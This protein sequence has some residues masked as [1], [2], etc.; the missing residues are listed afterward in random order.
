MSNQEEIN[1]RPDE[2]GHA[3]CDVA[4]NCFEGFVSAFARSWNCMSETALSAWQWL[5]DS[6]F[7]SP[8]MYGETGSDSQV[9]VKSTKEKERS[10]GS[11]SVASHPCKNLKGQ[12]S[13]PQ[14]EATQPT[15]QI[16][17]NETTPQSTSIPS[18]AQRQGAPQSIKSSIVTGQQNLQSTKLPS[19][20][21]ANASLRDSRKARSDSPRPPKIDFVETGSIFGDRKRHSHTNM[22][23][24]DNGRFKSPGRPNI[25]TGPGGRAIRISF[26]TGFPS[27]KSAESR[28]PSQ[29]AA[30]RIS[31]RSGESE[32][33][34]S[35]SLTEADT[36]VPKRAFSKKTSKSRRSR[37]MKS[38]ASKNFK[39]QEVEPENV[40]D[41]NENEQDEEIV[42][43]VESINKK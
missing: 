10:G 15:S 7:S 26:H 39:D 2:D 4:S 23:L 17:N 1:Q 31:L 29:S 30:S 6:V 5:Q 37:S 36:E 43:S 24:M 40:V 18:A 19:N 9:R 14:R 41:G 22:L 8:C 21:S 42:R 16:N 13:L 12:Q 28:A 25:L 27:I 32:A 11:G 33:R 20:A 38:T 34:D 35:N 3:T